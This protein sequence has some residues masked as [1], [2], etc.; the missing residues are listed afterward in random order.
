[1][2]GGFDLDP[3]RRITYTPRSS[4]N[5][6]SARALQAWLDDQLPERKLRVRSL[7]TYRYREPLHTFRHGAKV[8]NGWLEFATPRARTD[9]D[10]AMAATH[11]FRLRELGAGRIALAPVSGRARRPEYVLVIDGDDPL[12]VPFTALGLRR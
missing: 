5:A 12:F 8:E 7:G 6:L 2:P 3:A 10:A 9:L 4:T 11:G 1:M